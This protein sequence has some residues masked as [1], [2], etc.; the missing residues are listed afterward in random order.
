MKRLSVILL[1]VCLLFGCSAAP[2]PTT[3][4]P[5]T[6][7]TRA[8][9]DTTPATTL[10]L[11]DVLT[12]LDTYWIAREYF[13]EERQEYRTTESVSWYLDL[14]LYADGTA[15]FRD[16]HNELSIMNE[17]SLNMQ[18]IQN[19][20]RQLLLFTPLSDV[21]ILQGY[22]ADPGTL[23]LDYRGTPIILE[24]APMPQTIGESYCPAELTGTWV[25]VTAS[26]EGDTWELMPTSFETLVFYTSADEMTLVADLEYRSQFG[27]LHDSYH[28]LTLEIL[29]QP[30]YTGCDNEH[31]SV[32][33]HEPVETSGRALSVTLTDGNTLLLQN[34]YTIDGA[35]AIA[36]VT[37]WRMP[38][39]LSWWEVT[40][41][42]LSNLTWY[43]ASTVDRQ[44]GYCDP[45]E[46]FKD[47]ELVLDQNGQ[48]Y[49]G[50]ETL[51]WRVGKGN[52]IMLYPS[53]D[54]GSELWL[55]G[56]VFA[57]YSVGDYPFHE[58][59]LYRNGEILRFLVAGY[60]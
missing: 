57:C 22:P 42:E 52:T 59:Y 40:E 36:Y 6:Q 3:D 50:N 34:R 13:D 55:G 15:R 16:I 24:Q 53:E 60:G 47:L 38:P 31:W 37:Y 25:A 9:Q 51:N 7:Q 46:E 4:P 12:G 21:P 35:P 29:D 45:P 1:T 33:L 44:G 26:T 2:A 56:A 30:L 49:L 32:A 48:C 28:G 11:A 19:E 58:M 8:T 18:W 43:C 5:T 10:A 23:S 20:D 17:D 14:F 54:A 39:A 27:T 41:Q